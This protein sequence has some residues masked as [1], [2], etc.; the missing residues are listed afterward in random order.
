MPAD[1][2]QREMEIGKPLEGSSNKTIS[3]L[4]ANELKWK[5]FRPNEEGKWILSL[6]LGDTSDAGKP[7]KVSN[8]HMPK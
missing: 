7:A 8:C 3:D 4:M 1:R 6:I 5:A 2:R